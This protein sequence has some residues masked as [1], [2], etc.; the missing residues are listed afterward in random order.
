M[1]SKLYHCYFFTATINSWKVLLKNDQR[2]EIVYDII[3]YMANSKRASIHSFV[4]MPNHVHIAL[5][6]HEPETTNSF[7]RDFL[8]FTSQQL[9]KLLIFENNETELNEF[10]STQKD[11]IYH[12]WERRAK[13]IALENIPI[14]EQK[15][16]YI[17]Q[18]PLQEKW[19]LA[20][21]PEDYFWS[22]ASYYVLNSNQHSFIRHY[23]E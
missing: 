22:S 11:R 3:K 8:K 17:H 18:N 4:I 13:W 14:L 16:D 20:K 6:L 9:I 2:K 19:N 10:T 12:I 21:A 1:F 5:T 15:I 23:L 7:Q